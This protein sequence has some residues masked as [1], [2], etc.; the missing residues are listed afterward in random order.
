MSRRAPVAVNLR[1]TRLATFTVDDF[2]ACPPQRTPNSNT[3]TPQGPSGLQ[4]ETGS[5]QPSN[6]PYGQWHVVKIQAPVRLWTRNIHWTERPKALSLVML[7]NI[8]EAIVTDAFYKK[9]T[10]LS[11]DPRCK[12][13]GTLAEPFPLQCCVCHGLASGDAVSSAS[14]FNTVVVFSVG[15]STVLALAFMFDNWPCP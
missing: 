12:L 15:F 7:F 2:E 5:G 3:V 14:L 1:E 13:S 8:K 11:H 9:T 6:H 10:T 4:A